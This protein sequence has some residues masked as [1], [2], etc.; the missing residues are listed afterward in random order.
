MWEDKPCETS[1]LCKENLRASYSRLSNDTT[2]ARRTGASRDT[3]RR[4]LCEGVPPVKSK[5][6]IN[7]NQYLDDI[8]EMCEKKLNPSAMYR[9]LKLKGFKGCIKSFTG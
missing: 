7:Y 1:L 9:Q 3:V 5:A 8:Y 6:V 4:Y 2:I